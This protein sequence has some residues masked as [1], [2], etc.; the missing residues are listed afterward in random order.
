MHN[1]NPY[2][3]PYLAISLYTFTILFWGCELWLLW[4]TQHYVMCD[5][6]PDKDYS[7]RVTLTLYVRKMKYQW[8]I[9]NSSTVDHEMIFLSLHSVYVSTVFLVV[10]WLNNYYK[11][12]VDWHN[13][14]TGSRSCSITLTHLEAFQNWN[15]LVLLFLSRI[16]HFPSKIKNYKIRVSSQHKNISGAHSRLKPTYMLRLEMSK[17]LL[18][19][20]HF[21]PNTYSSRLKSNY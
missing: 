16:P 15:K 10:N 3:F 20:G 6:A 19:Q 18:I 7:H 13:I 11:I 17:H 21:C 9:L 14:I 2:L 5:W 8:Y 12:P 4:K 1:P